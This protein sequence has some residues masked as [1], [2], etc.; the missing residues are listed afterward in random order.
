MIRPLRLRRFSHL[1]SRRHAVDLAFSAGPLCSHSPSSA[2]HKP[3]EKEGFCED[4]MLEA[5]SDE[6]WKQSTHARILVSDAEAGSVIERGGSAIAAVQSTSGAHVQLSRRGQLLPRLPKQGPP[7]LRPLPSGHGRRRDHPPKNHL[8]GTLLCSA[9]L[10]PLLCSCLV[11][12]QSVRWSSVHWLILCS[13]SSA[14]ASGW[15]GDRQWAY[16]FPFLC[17]I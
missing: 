1:P 6:L 7:P 10:C 12:V 8:P 16:R 13:V 15:G 17:T 14:L 9:L 2:R 11:S 4:L 3:E 5:I